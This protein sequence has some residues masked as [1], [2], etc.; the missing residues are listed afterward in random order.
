MKEELVEPL[1]Y[2]DLRRLIARKAWE[3]WCPTRPLPA[4][5]AEFYNIAD[6]SIIAIH[7]NVDRIIGQMIKSRL[8]T[9]LPPDP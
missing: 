2:S 5:P 4:I 7:Q 1:D 9:L 6:M 8:E 3:I